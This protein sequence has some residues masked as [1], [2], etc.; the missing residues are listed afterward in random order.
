VLSVV[1]PKFD[2][3]TETRVSD[4]LFATRFEFTVARMFSA[5]RRSCGTANVSTVAAHSST[6]AAGAS[7]AAA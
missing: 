2:T 3:L 7:S 4:E 5:R 1:P 6:L